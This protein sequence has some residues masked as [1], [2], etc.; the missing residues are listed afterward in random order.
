MFPTVQPTT[1]QTLSKAS[2]AEVCT[3]WVLPTTQSATIQT[4]SSKVSYHCTSC[5]EEA[6]CCSILKCWAVS[7]PVFFTPGSLYALAAAA[8]GRASA[9]APLVRCPGL[10]RAQGAVPYRY[11]YYP[12]TTSVSL[13]AYQMMAAS[14]QVISIFKKKILPIRQKTHPTQRTTHPRSP[15]HRGA[16]LSVESHHETS[17]FSNYSAQQCSA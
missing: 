13:G 12:R 11:S 7:Q 5:R 2:A 6:L 15:S 9:S 3:D 14:E 16:A 10:L 8:P 1:Y 17:R 4:E